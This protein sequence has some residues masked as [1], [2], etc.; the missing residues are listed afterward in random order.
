VENSSGQEMAVGYDSEDH[1]KKVTYVGG[2]S[3]TL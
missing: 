2:P 1:P 3:F